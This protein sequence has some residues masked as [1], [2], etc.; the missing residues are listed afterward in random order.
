[1]YCQKPDLV[2]LYLE[3]V[4]LVSIYIESTSKLTNA[5]LTVVLEMVEP[6]LHWKSYQ[7]A[8]GR[9]YPNSWLIAYSPCIILKTVFGICFV[10]TLKILVASFNRSKLPA[11]GARRDKV[12]DAVVGY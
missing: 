7:L 11:E 1:M 9:R 12:F 3:V 2:T 5:K 8:H 6:A 4:V 10:L